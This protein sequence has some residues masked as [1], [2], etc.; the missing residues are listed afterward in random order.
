VVGSAATCLIERE[1]VEIVVWRTSAGTHTLL[2]TIQSGPA[3]IA[4]GD[5]WTAMISDLNASFTI[6]RRIAERI[7]KALNGK[8]ITLSSR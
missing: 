1:P 5:T 2:T 7:A 6:Q 8:A 4:K 3:A